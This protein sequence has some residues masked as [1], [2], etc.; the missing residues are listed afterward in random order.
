MVE[1]ATIGEVLNKATAELQA[2][3]IISAR[4]DAELL[5]SHALQID[6]L[7]LYRN[8]DKPLEA[9][10][11][12]TFT[13]LLQRRLNFEPIA[14]IL[15][16]KEFWGLEFEVGP[17]VMVPRP[18]TEVLLEVALQKL[19]KLRLHSPMIFDIGT[20]CGSLSVAVAREIPNC[21]VFAT[22]ISP[23]ALHMA[24][25][26]AIR[27]KVA[28]QLRFFQADLFPPIEEKADLIISNPP[29]VAESEWDSLARDIRNYEPPQALLA[30]KDGLNIIRKLIKRGPQYLERG[31][32]L[33]FEHSPGQLELIKALLIQDTQF[34]AEFSKDYS[35]K[36]RVTC[37]LYLDH[38]G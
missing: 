13:D 23:T 17:E 6:R 10:K 16:R 38:H 15:G 11:S 33:I 37:L 9:G 32:L 21:K 8:L 30:G 4:L 28:G 19:N 5:L 26:N 14:Y 18:E 36:V 31:G 1:L 29:Y 22:D 12:K 7:E 25:R 34:K 35:G 27:H 24:Q 3:G 20:G 2:R